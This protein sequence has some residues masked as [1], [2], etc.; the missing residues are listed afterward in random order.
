ME[1]SSTQSVLFVL[2]LATAGVGF[3]ALVFFLNYLLS[4]SSPSAEK[5][6]PYECGMEPI[7]G[8]WESVR[9]R[10]A[11]IAVLFVLFDAEATLMF[12]VADGLK[13][14]P[15]AIIEVGLFAGLLALGLAYA[16]RKG[17]LEWR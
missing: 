7:G 6:E 13:G 11:A 5:D 16:W 8:P 2:G 3:I 1:G 9:L 15:L 14:N 12:A 4:P 10:F 17:A